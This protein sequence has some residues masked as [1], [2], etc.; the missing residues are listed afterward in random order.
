MKFLFIEDSI[1]W[2]VELGVSIV[3]GTILGIFTIYA[4][5]KMPAMWLCDYGEEPGDELYGERI[6]EKPSVFFFC[7]FFI[8]VVWRLITL[9]LA[10]F[11]LLEYLQVI[12]LTFAVWLMTQIGIADRKYSI[13][14]DQH[15]LALAITGLFLEHSILGAALGA[16]VLFFVGLIGK[17]LLK[18]ETMGYGDIKLLAAIGFMLGTG[19][20][21]LV[22]VGTML[23]SGVVFAIGL[24]FK[25]LKKEDMV[26][27]GPY[28]VICTIVLMLS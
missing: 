24:Y 26:P 13:I 21:A 11:T 8:A 23:L 18:Q 16:G 3:A 12:L 28:I 22:L 20:V 4:F 17:L 7:L 1:M 15:V 19:Y 25:K 10:P 5:N 6:K 9:Y 14:P 27:L 2:V